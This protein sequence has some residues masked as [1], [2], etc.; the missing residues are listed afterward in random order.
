MPA[1]ARAL[2]RALLATAL[3]ALALALDPL[4]GRGLPWLAGLLPLLAM[5]GWPL[6]QTRQ[7]GGD[8]LGL[9]R[10]T[11]PAVRTTLWVSAVTAALFL[12][13]FGLF[14]SHALDAGPARWSRL[15]R[16]PLSWQGEPDPAVT[17]VVVSDTARG[18]QVHNRSQTAVRL[19]PTCVPPA[20][21]RPQWLPRGGRV[22]LGRPQ[23]LHVLPPDAALASRPALVAGRDATPL[24]NPVQPPQSLGWLGSFA[25]LQLV[26]V[27]LPEELLFRGWMLPVLLQRAGPRGQSAFWAVVASA[28]LFA[29]IHLVD[30]PSPDRLLVFF[31]A[32]LFGWLRLQTGSVWPSVLFHAWC[33]CLLAAAQAS[34]GW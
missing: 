22:D 34:H 4:L 31:P 32:L 17:G 13:A 16:A 18:L 21:C 14:A 7:Q 6:W 23:A 9:A 24:P 28:G 12:P 2:R 25:L 3:C 30:Q 26:G 15:W 20:H 19:E 33:N 1:P 5:M 8:P 11:W 29:L 10:P 27:A